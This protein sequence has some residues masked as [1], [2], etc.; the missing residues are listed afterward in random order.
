MRSARSG[1]VS[2]ALKDGR[3]LVTGGSTGSGSTSASEIYDPESN[4]WETASNMAVSRAGHT[5]ILLRDGHV[6]IAGGTGSADAG[7]LVEVYDPVTDH[8]SLAGQLGTARTNH[9]AGLLPNDNIII[10]GGNDA[11]GNPL[12]SAEIFNLSTGVSTPAAPLSQ[13]RTRAI[14]LQPLQGALVAR[15]PTRPGQRH[16]ARRDGHAPIVRLLPLQEHM[17]LPRDP[18]MG[19]RRTLTRRSLSRPRQQR[20]PRA[21]GAGLCEPPGWTRRCV[22]RPH[23][24]V[25]PGGSLRLLHRDS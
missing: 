25:Q 1:H 17:E 16:A 18:V 2:V 22:R 13:A 6:L 21:A 5:A 15:R 11:G 12:S 4:S 7:R 8:Y 24:R 14:S 23:R 9:V 3:V 20:Q 10:A 19:S